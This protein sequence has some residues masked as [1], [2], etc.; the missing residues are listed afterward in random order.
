MLSALGYLE[1]ARLLL[2]V[3]LVKFLLSW[4]RRAPFPPGPKPLPVIGN[5]LDMPEKEEWEAARKWGEKYGGSRLL[6]SRDS[7]VQKF[8]FMTL[9]RSYRLRRSLWNPVYLLEQLSS[10]GRLTGEAWL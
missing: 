8:D 5:V 2:G 10:S 7:I 4:Y 9:F 1:L 6:L 3:Y